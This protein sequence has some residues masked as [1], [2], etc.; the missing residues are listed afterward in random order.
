MKEYKIKHNSFIGGWFIP[1]KICDDIIKYFKKN[2]KFVVKGKTYSEDE[3]LIINSDQKDSNDIY[4]HPNN[5]DYPFSE[6]RKH[7]QLCLNEYLKKYF[8]ANNVS[9]FNINGMYN[10]QHYPP[11]GGF[12]VWHFENAGKTYCTRYLVFMTYLNNVEKAG[13]EFF[14]QKLTTPCKKGLTLI[15]PTSFTH[16]H[17]GQINKKH[18]KYIVTGWFNF[19]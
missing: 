19:I 14:Y 18:E 11:N 7:L 1:N 9:H 16:T 5:F 6:Y 10:I 2:K 3:K 17:R 4:V 8:F 12:K 15:W 13:T